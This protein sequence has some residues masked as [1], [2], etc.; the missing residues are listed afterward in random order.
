MAGVRPK[1]GSD[2]FTLLLHCSSIKL[3][4]NDGTSFTRWIPACESH[5]P[6]VGGVANAAAAMR[7]LLT[8]FCQRT[9][10]GQTFY[11]AAVPCNAG[12]RALKSRSH[13]THPLN[14]LSLFAHQLLLPYCM[15]M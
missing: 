1:T 12:G 2:F 8:S 10:S 5:A 11:S 13:H 9:L 3:S 4:S 15:G 7:H 14:P 6:H